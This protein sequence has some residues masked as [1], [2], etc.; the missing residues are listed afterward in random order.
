MPFQRISDPD[1]DQRLAAMVA[2]F[3]Q[4]PDNIV[5]HPHGHSFAEIERIAHAAGQQLA[6]QIMADALATHAVDQPVS[7]ACPRC[8]DGCRLTRKRRQLLTGD[9]PVIYDEPAAHCVACRR[10]FFPDAAPTED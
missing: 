7:S 10:D 5:D 6:A 1:H 3:R 2:L 4:Q 9:G 8:G